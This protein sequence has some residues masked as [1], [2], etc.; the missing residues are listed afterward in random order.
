M[1]VMC[2][3]AHALDISGVVYDAKTGNPASGVIVGLR[4]LDMVTETDSKGEFSFTGMEKG[5]YR[6][7]F[8]HRDYGNVSINIRVK[9][10]FHIVQKLSPKVYDAG[11]RTKSYGDPLRSKGESTIMRNDIKK[12]PMRGAGDSLHLIQS[13]PGIGGGF[14]LA[15]VP[16]IRSTNPLFNK[17]YI[18]DIPVDYPY[19]YA[20]GFVPLFS[21]INEES[22][23][24][25]DVIKG[26]APIW[27]GDNL[28]NVILIRSADAEKGGI[29][30]KMILDP[31]VPLMP[32]FSVS[33]VPNDRLSIT[34]AGRRTTA[35]M[36]VDMN[37]TH[38]YLADYFL[39]ASYVL[40]DSHRI[41]AVGSGSRDKVAFNDLSTRSGYSAN[42]ITWEFRASD[43][44]LV[45]TVLSNQNMTQS[46]ENKKDY[47]SGSG[48][49]IKFNPDQYR[50]FQ[51][52]VLSLRPVNIRAGYEAVKYRGGC[53][54]NTSLADIAGIKFYKGVTTDQKLSFPMEGTSL[55][56]FAG[57]DGTLS[58]FGY[59]AGVKYED[60]GPIDER[61]L[62]Y[63]I[64][65]DYRLSGMSSVYLKHGRYYAH[66]DVYYYLGNIHPDFK[67]AEARNFAIGANVIPVSGLFL[68]AE[69]YYCR[70]D[71]LCPG[72]VFNVDDDLA[73]KGMQ[74]H[75]FSEEDDG[76]TFGMEL[77]GRGEW[78][79]FEGW[80]SYAY[81]RTTRNNASERKFRSDFEQAHLLRV[82]LSKTWNRWT[83]A[84]IWHMTSSLPYT[85]VS[86]YVYNGSTYTAEYGKRN[87]A[88]FAMNKRLDFR[89]TYRTDNDTR[90]SVECWNI[91]FFRN[92]AVA[93]KKNSS[94]TETK[95][96]IPFFIW[97]SLEKPL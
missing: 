34:A 73:K 14:S 8:A 58:G 85:P 17:Y 44:L 95:N 19:H 1:C 33:A 40:N 81:S 79:G 69:M 75:P 70:F 3:A 76:N 96:D 50:I 15:T 74:L 57:V 93:E 90:L 63:D 38:F 97:L 83:A 24:S 68:N 32:A 6:L 25:V 66:P 67:L 91:L 21:S 12:Y 72:T 22:I 64:N 13:L 78:K 77:T 23:E 31:L 36:L 16:I 46:L 60:Y 48:A 26:N 18:D 43:E 61:A 7:T 89:G 41:T 55:V 52:A 11:S 30:G 9:R 56:G 62:S 80:M 2:G 54:G 35:D 59:D 28:G 82:V 47:N 10:T 65:A 42:G 49:E 87:S 51:T 94:S 39:K 53:S 45:K 71:N 29:N 27:T 37:K 86:Q 20:A 84:M 5:F 88:D 92:N 4:E